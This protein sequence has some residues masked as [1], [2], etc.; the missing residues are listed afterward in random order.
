MKSLHEKLI[1]FYPL[2]LA[3]MLALGFYLGTNYNSSSMSSRDKQEA[4]KIN[5]ILNLIEENYVDEVD[6]EELV[7]RSI[8]SM[9]AE[10]D[11]HSKYIPARDLQQ[12]QETLEGKFEG[13]GIR[14]LIH[15][16]TLVVTKP[17][18]GGPSK[19]AGIAAG[20]K[21]IAVDGEEISGKDLSI[22]TVHDKLKDLAG[23]PVVLTILRKGKQQDIKVIRDAIPLPSVDIYRMLD[24]E[25]GYIKIASFSE[26]TYYEFLQAARSLRVKGMRK[27]VLDL[28]N[29]GGGYLEQSWHIADEF[30]ERGKMIVYTKGKAQGKEPYY[31]ERNGNLMN[32]ETA[33]LI[34]QASASASE[35]LAGA[36]QDNDRAI[37]LGRR[38]FGKGL[39]QQPKE[40]QDGSALR[41][42]VA[43]YYTP[44]GR[45]I[46]KPYGDGINYEEDY[47]SR[48]ENGEMFEPDSSIFVDSLK[49]VTPGGKVVYGGGGIMPDIF[50]PYDTSGTS[51]YLSLL[52][53]HDAFNH[54][55]FDYCDTARQKI[56]ANGFD[57]YYD[58]FHVSDS[59]MLKFAN[60][61]NDL[62]DISVSD[63]GLMQ[64]KRRIKN[65]IKARI[66]QH[67]W[68]QQEFFKIIHADDRDILKAQEALNEKEGS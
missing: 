38:S 14:F 57:K 60:Y 21:I 35:I 61:A 42:T 18:D 10:L 48:Y 4:V 41:L 54:F 59:L 29:N 65:L 19:K 39:V 63:Y 16:D 32:V 47:V 56:T 8:E 45:C 49:K 5:S 27:L 51:S 17:I 6:R 34:N 52:N 7:E 44:T 50:V 68:G 3:V 15:R 66:A 1:P 53:Y 33:V 20:D 24:D 58:Q 46:Q 9:L 62:F 26:P 25:T 11:P 12:S 64:S 36:L 22:K 2:M 28:R 13:V 43:R 55:A 67:I 30:L 37:I 40:L 31:S 23:T